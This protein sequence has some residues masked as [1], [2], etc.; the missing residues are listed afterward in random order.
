MFNFNTLNPMNA[1][2]NRIQ[3]SLDSSVKH[4]TKVACMALSGYLENGIVLTNNPAATII[5]HKDRIDFGKSLRP[6]LNS[7]SGVLSPMFPFFPNYYKEHQN[8]IYR[9]DSGFSYS[10]LTKTLDY[11]GIFAPTEPDNAEMFKLIYPRFQ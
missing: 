1:N 11:V 9:F 7:Y 6:E 5:I 2:F 4:L 10:L 3:I 8:I